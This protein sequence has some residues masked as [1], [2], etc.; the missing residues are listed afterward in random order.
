M[1]EILSQRVRQ[2]LVAYGFAS[3]ALVAMIGSL[4]NAYIRD[5]PDFKDWEKAV[6]SFILG[7]ILMSL[8]LI[9]LKLP[10][11]E[12]RDWIDNLLGG[13]HPDTLTNAVAILD[14][15]IIKIMGI[16]LIVTGITA[17][18]PWIQALIT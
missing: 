1:F 9:I 8:G 11:K 13:N 14:S 6:P 2:H 16:L 3:L 18:G 12:I 5:D 15:I 4:L 7:S 17:I 10:F